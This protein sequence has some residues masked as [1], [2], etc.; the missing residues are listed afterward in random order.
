MTTECDNCGAPVT[1]RYARVL[2]IDG[3][4]PACPW[5]PDRMPSAAEP[6]G[7]LEV[8]KSGQTGTDLEH[9]EAEQV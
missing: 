8:S 6:G 4:V 7:Y 9:M 2:A 3:A 1:D 5:C